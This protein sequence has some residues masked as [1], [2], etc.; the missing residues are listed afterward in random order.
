MDPSPT[1]RV[2][3]AREAEFRKVGDDEFEIRL[4]N[5]VVFLDGVGGT[6]WRLFD[7]RRSIEEA[8]AEIKA[9]YDAPPE[10]AQDVRSFVE[11]MLA[12]GLLVE[13]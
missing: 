8:V 4:R 11:E 1:T 13:A 6:L 12:R 7:G 5:D 3:R 9:S 2:R 10:V